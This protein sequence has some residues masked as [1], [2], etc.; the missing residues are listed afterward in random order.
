[1]TAPA[2]P[3]VL[4]PVVE[5]LR[6]AGHDV[7]ITARDYAQTL[8][9]LERLG[10]EHTV[11]GRHGGASRAG[12]VRALVSRTARMQRFGRRGF[13]L[14]AAHGSNDLALA[15]GRGR[16]VLMVRPPPD[17]SL[18]PRRANKLFPAVLA[19]LGR[20]EDVHAVVIPRT[21]RQRHY[22]RALGLPSVIVADG[23]VDA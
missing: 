13:D 12:K 9:L 2:H 20:R 10:L 1:M 16:G 6:A 22:T 17:V 21:E 19:T 7:E 5:R 23:A 18:S 8:G 14:A 11:I 15:A 3:I 4:R